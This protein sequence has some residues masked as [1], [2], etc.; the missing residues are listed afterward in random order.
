LAS[1]RAAFGQGL[2]PTSP[3]ADLN[4]QI[5]VSVLSSFP[6]ELF[7]AVG[8]FQSLWLLRLSNVASDAQGMVAELLACERARQVPG[9]IPERF[10]DRLRRSGE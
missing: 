10:R 8:L 7:D 5:A 9:A 6:P 2:G 1:L 3:N 4:G